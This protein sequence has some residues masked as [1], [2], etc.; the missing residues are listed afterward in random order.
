MPR[1]GSSRP[2]RPAAFVALPQ[3]R[4]ATPQQ[5]AE[6]FDQVIE[7]LRAQPG[8]T[9]AAAAFSPPLTG[10]ARTTYVVAGQPLPPVGQRPIVG[11]NIVSDG[12]FRLLRIRLAEGRGFTADDRADSPPVCVINETFAR[13]VFPGTVPRSARG[14][15]SGRRTGASKSSA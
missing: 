1:P 10:G 11:I 5:Q 9:D 8:V 2:A 14:C 15:C 12:Y 13:R 4:Y 7:S 3:A 6:F